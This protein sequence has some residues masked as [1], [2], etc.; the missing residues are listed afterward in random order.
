MKFL[1]LFKIGPQTVL[2]I[3]MQGIFLPRYKMTS[4]VLF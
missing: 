3:V 2:L 1:N 4:L